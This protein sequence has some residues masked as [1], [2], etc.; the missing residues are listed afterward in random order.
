MNITNQEKIKSINDIGLC[1]KTMI[2]NRYNKNTKLIYTDGKYK[3]LHIAFQARSKSWQFY[4]QD[5]NGYF[6]IYLLCDDSVMRKILIRRDETIT[7]FY[8][9]MSYF[10]RMI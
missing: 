2:K 8:V 3:S 7:N 5:K 6:I 9:K 4:I 1:L 10:F